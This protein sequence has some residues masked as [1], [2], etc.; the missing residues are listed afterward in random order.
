MDNLQIGCYHSLSLLLYNLFLFFVIFN[1]SQSS[2][3][4]ELVDLVTDFLVAMIVVS[5]L[6]ITMG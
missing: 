3:S 4:F 1:G 2:L 6:G 5:L